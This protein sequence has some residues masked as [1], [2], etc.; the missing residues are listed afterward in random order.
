[1]K[2]TLVAVGAVAVAI[3][4]AFWAI[5]VRVAE[6]PG[7]VACTAEAKLCPD[8]SAVGRTGPNCEFALC[9]SEALC[10]GGEC[11]VANG[12]ITLEARVGEELSGLDENVTPLTVIQDSRCPVGVQ[13]VWAGTVKLRARVVSGL[14]TSTPEFEIG[15]PITT[16]AETVTL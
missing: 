13:C 6:A 9:P 16:E 11:P 10:E 1:M 3:V 14:G 5:N 7:P 12:P 15:Q 8:G 4:A 2:N